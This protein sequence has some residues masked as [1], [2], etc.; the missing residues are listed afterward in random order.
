VGEG[1]RRRE[2]KRGGIIIRL[3]QIHCVT[4]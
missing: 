1:E 4:A 2:E 3:K